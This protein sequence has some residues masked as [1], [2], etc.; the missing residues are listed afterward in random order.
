MQVKITN[1]FQRKAK[2]KST[3]LNKAKST[4]AKK[5][6]GVKKTRGWL[7]EEGGTETRLEKWYGP[8]R[9]LFLPKGLL[10]P[11][12]V[13]SYLNG[14]LPG[15]YG[16]DPL[17]LGKDSEQVSKYREAE[18]IHARWAMLA[19]AGY[20]IGV[21]YFDSSI[22]TGLNNLYPGGLFD[23]L[24]IADDPDVFAELQVKEIKN[25]RLAMVSILAIAIQSYVTGEGLMR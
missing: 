20:S 4:P 12:E 6:S 23:P 22:F 11:S 1:I 10:D 15:D 18:L 3:T 2:T 17:G 25:G 19:S 5:T 8:N 24:G 13:P 7:G 14:Q 16:Y 9:A 21:G